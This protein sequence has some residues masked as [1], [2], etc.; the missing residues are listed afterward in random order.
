L[1][2]KIPFEHVEGAPSLAYVKWCADNQSRIRCGERESDPKI[3]NNVFL[4]PSAEGLEVTIVY[5][6]IGV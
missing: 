6:Y 4:N 3:A 1:I 2:E 5:D